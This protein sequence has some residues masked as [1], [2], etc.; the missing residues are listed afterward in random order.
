MLIVNN[1]IVSKNKSIPEII[2]FNR[3]R[4][5]AFRIFKLVTDD[6]DSWVLERDRLFRVQKDLGSVDCAFC[7]NKVGFFES[8]RGL[9]H[10]VYH[11]QCYLDGQEKYKY[12][13]VVH[14]GFGCCPTDLEKTLIDNKDIFDE[15][16]I[17]LN[18]WL[19]E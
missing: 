3:V 15:Y 18:R 13:N 5:E 12:A 8:R 10:G 9:S 11:D 17:L 4:S 16:S 14:F 2:E 6:Y 19:N 7:G 1:L